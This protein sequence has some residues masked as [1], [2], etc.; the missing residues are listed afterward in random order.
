MERAPLEFPSLSRYGLVSFKLIRLGN[1]INSRFTLGSIFALRRIFNWRSGVFLLML[2]I[3]FELLAAVHCVRSGASGT[4]NGQDWANAFPALPSALTRGD[5]YYIA[6]GSYPSYIFDDAASGTTL[7]TI[8]KATVADHG[9]SVGWSDTYGDGR[10]VFAYLLGF[11]TGYYIFD[12]VTGSGPDALNYGFK[13]DRPA[14]T[15]VEQKYIYIGLGTGSN[16]DGITIAHTSF[17]LPTNDVEKIA[18]GVHSQSFATNTTIRY[19]HFDGCQGAIDLRGHTTSV[20]EYCYFTNGVSSPSHHGEQIN[21]KRSGSQ[22][23]TNVTIRYNRFVNSTGTGM[24]VANDSEPDTYSCAGADIYGNL[25]IGCSSGGNGLITSTS[26][27]YWKNVRVYNNTFAMCRTPVFSSAQASASDFIKANAT[28]FVVMN[29]L[30]YGMSGLLGDSADQPITSDYNAYFQCTAIPTE[31]NAQISISNP[32]VGDGDYR[33]VSATMAGLRLDQEYGATPDGLIRGADGIWDRGAFEFGGGEPP[34]DTTAPVISGIIAVPS[35]SSAVVSWTTSEPAD[36]AVEYGLTTSYGQNVVDGALALSHSVIISNISPGTLL[37]YRVLARDAA[38]NRTNS[39]DFTLATLTADVTPPSGTLLLPTNGAVVSG[40][41]ALLA[42]AG[43]NPGGSGVAAVSFLV[44]NAPISTDVSLPYE[45]VWDSRTVTN[46]NHTLQVRVTDA[47]GNSGV[48][49]VVAI[50]VD[51]QPPTLTNGLVLQMEFDEV[52]GTSVADLSGNGNHG[53]LSGAS[54]GLGVQGN[55]VTLNGVDSS[56]RVET[57][58]SLQSV[59]N[60]VTICAWVN[61]A[62]NGVWQAVVRKVLQDGAHVFPYSAYDLMA[63]DQG[64]RYRA[65]LAVSRPDGV[66]EV[67]YGTTLLEYGRWCHLVGVYD[68]VQLSVYL[69]GQLSGSVPFTGAL[70]QPDQVLYVG[71]NGIGGDRVTGKIDDLRIFNRALSAQQIL[72]IYLFG[73]P[74]PPVLQRVGS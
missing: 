52:S 4:G 30:L 71:R 43:D 61:L 2:G 11:Q 19:C 41:V 62:S 7:I 46:G 26:K 13:V 63:E 17:S 3:Q 57:S 60:A 36:T 20:I 40:A 15:A 39:A 66:R 16:P 18:I 68:G 33:L 44:D 29:N 67:A 5:T 74:I 32:F 51:N 35:T 72:Q 31:L 73:K 58:A 28:G 34:V 42:D 1:M 25:F 27:A 65:R 47:V 70:A 21:M 54:W 23:C 49:A 9:I 48:S 56:L 38:G 6:S 53:T 37:H 59:T 50:S 8:K 12:G 22:P 14:D 45:V 64:G 10:V 55:G 69:N 24:I